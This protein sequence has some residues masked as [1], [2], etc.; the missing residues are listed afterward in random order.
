MQKLYD[1]ATKTR[2]FKSMLEAN[3][4]LM[5]MQQEKPKQFNQMF[6]SLRTFTPEFSRDPVV[7]GT[8]MRQMMENPIGAGGIITQ[9][10]MPH[11]KLTQRGELGT[12]M[13]AGGFKEHFK[14]QTGADMFAEEELGRK[15]ERA[16]LEHEK[17]LAD[18]AD[19]GSARKETA[20]A[21]QEASRAAAWQQ[22]S[23][24]QHPGVE[25][26]AWEHMQ[27]QKGRAQQPLRGN[28]KQLRFPG[29]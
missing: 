12:T 21:R 4:D 25:Q 20:R 18:L 22:T 13:A 8:Y 24:P 2:D 3:P 19:A 7:A 11:A 10:I 6:T 17:Q 5:Q 9:G 26:Q 23:L 29:M 28:R 15:R 27:Q 16:P 14:P 1:A